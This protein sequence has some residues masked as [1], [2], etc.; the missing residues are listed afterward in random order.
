M[1]HRRKVPKAV[2]DVFGDLF[3]YILEHSGAPGPREDPIEHLEG[4]HIKASDLRERLIALADHFDFPW[5][6]TGLSLRQRKWLAL[7][8]ER[9]REELRAIEESNF[10]TIKV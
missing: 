5:K 7:P 2:T 10:R 3:E 9:T 1:T 8:E 6:D 4:I